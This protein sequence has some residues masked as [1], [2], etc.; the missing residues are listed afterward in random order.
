[1]ESFTTERLMVRGMEMGDEVALFPL[2]SDADV[3]RLYGEAPHATVEETK[4]WV[5]ECIDASQARSAMVWSLVLRSTGSVIGMACLWNF[6]HEHRCAEVGFELDPGFWRQG[7]MSEALEAILEYG[8]SSV[9]LHRIEATPLAINQASR[10]LLLRFG[11]REEGVLR[12]RVHH[13]GRYLDEVYLALLHQEWA[14]R[15]AP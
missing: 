3:T 8:F 4:G 1:M 10:S 15:R 12:Q 5:Q 9:G 2:K 11:F 6:R 7:L 14:W 13:E